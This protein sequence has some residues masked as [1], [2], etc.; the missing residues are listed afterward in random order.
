MKSRKVIWGKFMGSIDTRR[1]CLTVLGIVVLLAC[2]QTASHFMHSIVIASP[3]DTILSL[4]S[5]MGE[6]RFWKHLGISFQR[7][8]TGI[9]IGG[10]AGFILGLAAGL[11]NTVKYIL[12]PLRWA[13]MSVPAVVVVVIAMLWFGM[14]STMVVFITALL[15]SPIVYINTV[16]GLEM[17]DSTIIEMSRLYKFPLWLRL[18]HVYIPALTGPLAA[19]MVLVVGMGVRIVILAEVMG[20]SE[21]IGYALSMTRSSLEIPALFAW[22]LVCIGIVG[23]IEYFVLRPI[24]QYVLRWKE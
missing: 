4:V 9:L 18:R 8:F 16:K 23:F 17:V 24:E 11:N 13:L 14:G 5:M 10:T 1:V 20:T 22:V 7:I 21:G 19:A 3:R 6:T 2:W 12:E 15:L